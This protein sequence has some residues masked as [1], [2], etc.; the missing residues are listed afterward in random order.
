MAAMV[1]ERAYHPSE[2]RVVCGTRLALI[3]PRMYAIVKLRPLLL[4]A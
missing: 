4:H 3:E 2:E 1:P